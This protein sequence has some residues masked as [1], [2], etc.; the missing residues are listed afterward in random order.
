MNTISEV[1]EKIKKM[2]GIKTKEKVYALLGTTRNS[3][4]NRQRRNKFPYQ[5]IVTYC[6][7]ENIDINELLTNMPSTAQPKIKQI[8]IGS[9]PIEYEQP[10]DKE[11]YVFVP[12]YDVQVSAGQGSLIHSEQIVSHLAFQENWIR[13][14]LGI[15][16]NHIVLIQAVGDSMNPTFNAGALLLVNTKVDRIKNDSIYIINRDG[17]LIVKRIQDLWN[18]QIKI[19]SD[20]PKYEPLIIQKTDTIKIVGEVVWIGQRN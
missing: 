8:K 10:S 20:N 12:R 1:I 15:D 4:F 11:G 5:E 14:E 2:K 19:K 9:I 7:R 6:L 13:Q 18:G 3:I 17:E 16:P